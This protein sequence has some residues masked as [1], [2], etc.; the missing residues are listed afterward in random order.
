V[1]RGTGLVERRLY[2]HILE[3][4]VED[5]RKEEERVESEVDHLSYESPR[6]T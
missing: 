3:I 4:H 1:E 5:N 6:C 2:R